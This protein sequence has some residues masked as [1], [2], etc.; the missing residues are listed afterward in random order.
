MNAANAA[1][2]PVVSDTV[3]FSVEDI[4]E[5]SEW[6]DTHQ[7]ELLKI[8]VAV[9]ELTDQANYGSKMFNERHCPDNVHERYDEAEEHRNEALKMVRWISNAETL[10][11]EAFREKLRLHYNAKIAAERDLGVLRQAAAVRAGAT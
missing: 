10:I 11:K 2:A 8:V 6:L 7:A 4:R 1:T 3:S 9:E 5:W